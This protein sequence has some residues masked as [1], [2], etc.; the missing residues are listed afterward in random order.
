VL[1]DRAGETAEQATARAK[2]NAIEFAERD[3]GV[4]W[5][6]AMKGGSFDWSTLVDRDGRTGPARFDAQ[7]WRANTSPWERYV[8]TPAGSV[9]HRLPSHDSGFANLKLAGDWT[10]TGIDGGC[11]EAAVISGM[12]AARAIT[13][14]P[15]EV[16]GRS[17]T[18]LRPQPREL[19]AY[20]EFGGRATA[21]SPFAC[22]GGRLRGL[23]LQGDGPSIATLVERLFNVPAGRGVEYRALGSNVMM[24]AGNFRRVTSLT[25][26]FDR[27]GAVRETQASFWIPV[28]A[29]RDLGDVFIAERLLLAVPYVLVDNPM[30][31]LGGRETFGY[32]K[33]MGRFDPASGL[34]DSVT[35]QAF[36]GNFGRNEGADWRDFID[37]SAGAP[38]ATAAPPQ[39]S[40]GPL[41]LVRHLVGDMPGLAE[42][43]ELIVGDIKLTTGL[44]ADL[45]AGRVGQ[46]FLKQF[47]DATDGTRAC[48]QAVVEAPVQI[49]RVESTLSERDWSIRVHSLDSH[50][51]GF[52]LGIDDQSAK[53]AFDIEIDFVV[54]DG[55]EVGGT[56]VPPA[57]LPARL[58]PAAD[59]SGSVIES[60]ARWIWREVT[61]FERAS[62]D[63][64][65]RI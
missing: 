5:P 28:L 44:I 10:A 62:L 21:P 58:P 7:Y 60:A 29:G 15:R 65:R 8:L 31:Y 14:E 23:L 20:V 42:G 1:D 55:Y 64:L 53:L 35:I 22:E 24:L 25:P 56:A 45:L 19:P 4:L 39:Q 61:G 27:W 9:K 17:M 16:P 33:V 54:E 52:E 18:W 47:R 26:P 6:G 3:L 2:E 63:W 13:G 11:V 50:P 43:A 38:R 48:Y 46:V 59:G 51:I 32:A 41:G 30:S 34:G 37:V 36:G 40:S 12:G 57:T 49:R